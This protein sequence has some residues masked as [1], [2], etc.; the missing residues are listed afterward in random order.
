MSRA[1]VVGLAAGFVCLFHP[2][3]EAQTGKAGRPAGASAQKIAACSLLPKNEVK[4]HLPWRAALDQMPIEEEPVGVSGSS[5]NYPSVFIQVLPFSRR[6]IELAHKK[7]GLETVAGVG[8]EAYFHNNRNRYAE[9]YVRVGTHLLTLQANAN[10]T[11]EA[12]RPGVLNLAKA[13]VQRLR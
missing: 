11:V 2:S 7:G 13:L 3:L 12:V 8:D 10:D 6:T 5:C 1:I 4:R 9:L